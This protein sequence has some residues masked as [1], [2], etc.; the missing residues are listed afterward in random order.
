M[1]QLKNATL[2]RG[3]KCLL[4]EANLLINQGEKVGLVGSNGAGKTSLFKLVM[5]KL[6][7]DQGECEVPKGVRIGEIRQDVPHGEQ[8]A[9]NYVLCGDQQLADIYT[10]L[11][12]AE[13]D[14]DGLGIADC[15]VQ[16][17]EIDGYSAE[18]RAAKILVGLGFSAEDSL[19]PIDDF[20]GGWRMRLNL[21]QVLMIP[22][23]LL[24]LDEP[25]NHLD[26][27]A[28]FWLE[29]WLKTMP[30]TLIIISH[31]R[32]FLDRVVN[33]IAFIDKQAIH[34]FT[35]SYSYFEEQYALQLEQQQSAHDKQ[36]RKI[37]H[38]MGFVRKLGAKATKAKQAQSRLKAIGRMEK[39]AAVHAQN[40]F[41]FE[42]KPAP[43]AGNPMLTIR[44]ANIGYGGE[45]V[46][47]NVSLSLHPGDRLALIGPNG[48]G[49]STLV[50]AI[51]QQLKIEG[52]VV[53]NSKLKIGYFTQYQIDS[54][55]L[56]HTAL[57][58]LQDLDEKITE[59]EARS[60]LGGFNFQDERVFECIKNFSGGEK[61]RLALA[62]LVWQQPNLLLLD[63]PSN[64]LDLEM[65]QALVIALQQYEGALI[66]IAHDRYLLNSLINQFYL[67]DQG[68]MVQFD[69]D[70]DDYEKWFMQR[71]QTVKSTPIQTN[72]KPIEK[73]ANPQQLAKLESKLDKLLLQAKVLETQLADEN[74]YID[75]SR[76]AEWQALEADQKLCLAKVA[77]L[78]ESILELL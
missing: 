54:L 7:T 16:L 44:N 51:A 68:Q 69:G 38:M 43:A 6:E 72:N 9:L 23:E 73:K 39:V 52:D 56:Q 47:N 31:D 14:D 24:L 48:A 37:E 15:H 22:C 78:E 46:L 35:G 10:R 33:R 3:H 4:K 66:L 59:K 65:R 61:A 34:S 17:A 75:P 64:H 13:A 28:I 70:M 32:D 12:K 49:K 67:L 27:E 40:P 42:F 18:S 76:K 58:H 77:E 74:L 11:A 2:Y 8:S 30:Q 29:N 53:F 36:Q 5:K 71:A 21:A 41:N 25:T 63:E 1:L 50:K 19:R 55:H 26:V 45:P 62:L 57:W 20:S 60:F